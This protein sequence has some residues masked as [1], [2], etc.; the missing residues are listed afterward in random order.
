MR[1][2]LAGGTGFV[3]SHVR[4][5]LLAK[6]HSIRLLVHNRSVGSEPGV[7]EVEGD[8]TLLSS[9]IDG[10]TGCDAT[11]NLIGI[12]REV[13]RRD[14]TFERIHVK[15]THNMISAALS[16]GV[17]RHLQMSALGTRADSPSGYFQSKFKGEQE[18]RDSGLDYTIFRP[19]IIFGPKDD[20]INKLAGYLKSFPATPVVGDGEYQIQ[21]I[22]ADD[23]ARCFAEA[24]EKPETIGK[25]YE[26][27]GPDRMSYNALLDTI[28]RVIGKNKVRKVKNPL[29][30]M[31]LI[32]PVLER[33]PF[34]PITSDQITMLV[35]GNACDG[36][37]RKTFVFEPT[38]FE[39]GIRRY[40]KP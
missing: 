6:G 29:L 7:E 15:A 16:A 22:S 1:I 14:I 8:V 18:V 5:A 9:F 34:F 2:F 35:Q 11:V 12:I 24:L 19:S 23:V 32:V 26:L 4:Q 3:G 28:G 39:E 31:R 27:C 17:R 33:F 40:L 20:F 37:W 36:N 21:P 38:S 13:P 30:L 25:T 10:V